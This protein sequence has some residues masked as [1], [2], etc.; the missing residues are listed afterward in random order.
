M[1][2]TSGSVAALLEGTNSG[3]SEHA[4]NINSALYNKQITCIR[5]DLAK[6]G[7]PAGSFTVGILGDDLQIVKVFGTQTASS[8]ITLQ[9][10]YMYC[11]P[12]HDYWTLSL[13]D[14]VGVFYN[15][16][17]ATDFMTVY[18]DSSSD[19]VFDGSNSKRS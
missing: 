11:L 19:N 13:Y 18:V 3:V 7:V 15:T 9:R 17:T 1:N 2:V 5:V 8:L 12:S 16:G 4:L 10:S 14:R 6:T